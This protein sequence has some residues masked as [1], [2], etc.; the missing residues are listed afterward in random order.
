[1]DLTREPTAAGYR[2]Y[3]ELRIA[4]LE[5]EAHA[6]EARALAE[7]AAPWR[8]EDARRSNAKHARGMAEQYRQ[9]AAG[10]RAQAGIPPP[11]RSQLPVLG[12]ACNEHYTVAP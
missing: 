3:D 12:C 11:Q 9:M 5:A 6:Y 4:Y 1:M 8:D 2:R 10:H 7:E